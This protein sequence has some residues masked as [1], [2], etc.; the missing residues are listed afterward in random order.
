MNLGSLLFGFRGR[1]GRAQ[2]WLSLLA[3][4]V[5][6]IGIS[7][8]GMLV[9]SEDVLWAFFAAGA[10]V[11]LVPTIAISLKR[12]HD[13]DK[14]VW[15]LVFFFVGPT[16]LPLGATVLAERFWALSAILIFAGFAVSL[17]SFVELGFLRGT[18]GPNR[19]GE[20]PLRGR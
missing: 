7:V 13:R 5:V 20:D 9:G 17:W 18:V 6:L 12:L 3:V 8:A 11:T 1:I 15:W 4:I 2:Y 19:F 16:A 10:I 14:G